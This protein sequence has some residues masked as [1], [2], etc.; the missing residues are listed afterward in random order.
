MP[1]NTYGGSCIA[2]LYMCITGLSLVC[3]SGTC[4]CNTGYYWENTKCGKLTLIT[5]SN[6]YTLDCPKSK[7][8]CLIIHIKVR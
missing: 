2:G 5:R 4:T 3:P 6:Y 1:R 7:A 8:K